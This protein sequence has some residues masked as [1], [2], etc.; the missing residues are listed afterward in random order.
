MEA[1]DVDT[2]MKSVGRRIAELRHGQN[3]T[4]DELATE[5]DVTVK[6][7]Q[8]VEGGA[9]NLT[10][11]SLVRVADLLDVDVSEL[12]AEPLSLDVRMGRP[13]KRAD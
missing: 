2:V 6:Y 7:V 1:R 3:W 8:R 13:P 4:Q 10:L 5:L 12:F 9:E 11:K